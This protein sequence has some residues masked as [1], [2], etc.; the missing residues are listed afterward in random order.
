MTTITHSTQNQILSVTPQSTLVIQTSSG[1]N[2][3]NAAES[4]AY[5][6]GTAIA[7]ADPSQSPVMVSDPRDPSTHYSVREFAEVLDQEFG[8]SLIIEYSSGLGVNGY[9]SYELNQVLT[10]I[11]QQT[12][13]FDKLELLTHVEQQTTEANPLL[14]ARGDTLEAVSERLGISIDELLL[15]NG[16]GLNASDTS[17][18]PGMVVRSTAPD[19]WQVGS[20]EAD[21]VRSLLAATNLSEADFL[22]M[23]GLAN[24][25]QLDGHTQF[26]W[27]QGNQSVRLD[28]NPTQLTLAQAAEAFGITAPQLSAYNGLEADSNN[29]IS[30]PFF[31]TNPTPFSGEIRAG[32]ATTL[33]DIAL[34]YGV[35]EDTLRALN[36]EL[37]SNA[38]SQGQRVR[39]HDGDFDRSIPSGLVVQENTTWNELALEVGIDA[40]LLREWNS[41]AVDLIN[42]GNQ[43]D[44]AAGTP[45][46][47]LAD[48]LVYSV[49][50]ETESLN[51]IANAF[52]PIYAA[53]VA[54]GTV[55]PEL[56]QQ[57]V[58]L[59][60]QQAALS[61]ADVQ[62]DYRTQLTQDVEFLQEI[63]ALFA[64][65]GTVVGDSSQLKNSDGTWNTGNWMGRLGQEL[66]TNYTAVFTQLEENGIDPVEDLGIPQQVVDFAGTNPAT[67]NIYASDIGPRVLFHQLNG[68]EFSTST[69]PAGQLT[70]DIND[71]RYSGAFNVSGLVAGRADSRYTGEVLPRF[72]HNGST[73]YATGSYDGVRQEPQAAWDQYSLYAPGN[74][75]TQAGNNFR[76]ESSNGSFLQGVYS[77]NW[78]RYGWV[79]VGNNPTDNGSA[80]EI[81]AGIQQFFT[82]Q[83]LGLQ[84]QISEF[85]AQVTEASNRHILAGAFGGQSSDVNLEI[86]AAEIAYAQP[87]TVPSE[88]QTTARE[89]LDLGVFQ[90]NLQRVIAAAED[91]VVNLSNPVDVDWSSPHYRSIE[92]RTVEGFINASMVQGGESGINF[93]ETLGQGESTW[94]SLFGADREV[95]V[96]ELNQLLNQASDEEATRAQS[97]LGMASNNIFAT[98][99]QQVV[100]LINSLENQSQ[101]GALRT[102]ADQ[103]R[104]IASD[105]WRDGEI[106]WNEGVESRGGDTQTWHLLSM[107]HP[108]SVGQSAGFDVEA[109]AQENGIL[110][111]TFQEAFGDDGMIDQA[112]VLSWASQF[113]SHA[114]QL[115]AQANEVASA[116][117]VSQEWSAFVNRLEIIQVEGQTENGDIQW[118]RPLNSFFGRDNIQTHHI[119]DPGQPTSNQANSSVDFQAALIESGVLPEGGFRELFLENGA[120]GRVASDRFAQIVDAAKAIAAETRVPAVVNESTEPVVEESP[121]V[122]QSTGG[123]SVAPTPQ[124]I[125][126]DESGRFYIDGKP[127]DPLEIATGIRLNNIAETS[128]TLEGLL[129][130]VNQRVEKAEFGQDL[131][132][133]IDK[134]ESQMASAGVTS[135]ASISNTASSELA[136][137]FQDDLQAL[138]LK[139]GVTS[140]IEEFAPSLRP[141]DNGNYTSSDLNQIKAL[142]EAFVDTA[143]KDN[144]REQLQ[145]QQQNGYLQQMI[146]N[147]NAIVKAMTQ[148]QAD[149]ARRL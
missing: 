147:L 16:L 27:S 88:S 118:N 68:I 109:F 59:Q 42:G 82:E 100:G 77:I 14:I 29:P 74:V 76:A 94:N 32:S 96:R 7:A 85:D 80:D 23:N 38:I 105:A 84:N 78:N 123:E 143:T 40:D 58:D 47:Y 139:N 98:A 46:R 91:G 30:T 17:L 61:P 26:L 4:S 43:T 97:L 52:N 114:N 127:S 128:Q 5:L 12:R 75:I 149:L 55:T 99:E 137:Q 71:S 65:D 53:A 36:P 145:I 104:A 73:F 45:I 10:A 37:A 51:V 44:I 79:D 135:L 110:S 66:A 121:E 141:S 125:S 93:L 81:V 92:N 111:G 122:A 138:A 33:S 60:R 39:V 132:E 115:M 103:L 120:G 1:Q 57:R 87:G 21:S 34:K 18:R 19:G 15:F 24:M 136:Q 56:E 62:A 119:I 25:D 134:Y 70:A 54:S 129:Q 49:D 117:Q 102:F 20:V 140:P 50:Y 126:T 72:D 9:D 148:A 67:Y 28:S 48:P 106:H 63:Q 142:T 13:G 112:T 131:I 83:T 124:N 116:P 8:T 2:T 146:E 31:V 90:Y 95:S 133:L 89:Y 11:N 22:T 144:E 113:D 108:Y 41:N 3:L 69:P 107:T 86:M 64:N 35:T 6:F 130:G 101:S